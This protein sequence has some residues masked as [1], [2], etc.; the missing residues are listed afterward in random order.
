MLEP[1]SAGKMHA[2]SCSHHCAM[3]TVDLLPT[4]LSQYIYIY[5]LIDVYIYIYAYRCLYIYIFVIDVYNI[6]L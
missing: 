4:V 5:M 1:R 2:G 3:N 6:C